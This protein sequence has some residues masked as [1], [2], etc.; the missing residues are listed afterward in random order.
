MYG[1]TWYNFLSKLKYCKLES[2]AS[3]TSN[4]L[5]A[6]NSCANTIYNSVKM[7]KFGQFSSLHGLSANFKQVE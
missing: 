7:R 6:T 2:T 5:S 1:N 4:I 3:C